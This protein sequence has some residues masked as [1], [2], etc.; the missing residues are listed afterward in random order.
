MIG[1]KQ[2]QHVSVSCDHASALIEC[3]RGL[4]KLVLGCGCQPIILVGVFLS[5]NLTQQLGCSMCSF[6]CVTCGSCRR[7]RYQRTDNATSRRRDRPCVEAACSPVIPCTRSKSTP[8]LWPTCVAALLGG[9]VGAESMSC[10]QAA[11]VGR[12][13]RK[14]QGCGVS[15]SP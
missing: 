2:S 15:Q 8:Q 1:K 4:T 9:G 12:Q 3:G 7:Q 11:S 5:H 13:R 6:R 10:E 14:K